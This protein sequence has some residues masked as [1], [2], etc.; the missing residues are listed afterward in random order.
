[1]ERYDE[2]TGQV[3]VQKTLAANSM[4]TFQWMH[5]SARNR[6]TLLKYRNSGKGAAC[7][8]QM[9][10]RAFAFYADGIEPGSSLVEDIKDVAPHVIRGV[11]E[12]LKETR[13]GTPWIWSLLKNK[14]PEEVDDVFDVRIVVPQGRTAWDL[15]LLGPQLRQTP[16]QS[17]TFL[18]I[19]GLE[20]RREH[21]L[22]GLIK[23]PNLAFLAVQ[24]A[25]CE[26]SLPYEGGDRLVLSWGRAVQEREAFT[27]LR[28]LVLENFDLSEHALGD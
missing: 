15:D 5:H 4:K 23:I 26:G 1:M 11:F 16:F 28:V 14:F 18:D 19:C 10:S 7:M 6:S 21:L 8:L 2:S 20:I 3:Y 9:A 17:L 24:K 25:R 22:S 13:T 12:I 27:K